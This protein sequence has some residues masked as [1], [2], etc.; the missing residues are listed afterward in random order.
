MRNYKEKFNIGDR[1]GQLTIGEMISRPQDHPS[2]DSTPRSY[3]RHGRLREC[4]CECGKVVLYSEAALRSPTLRSCGCLKIVSEE[5]RYHR[6]Q[7]QANYQSK[8]ASID[9][10]IDQARRAL[11]LVLDRPWMLK[12]LP[13]F[14][15]DKEQAWIRLNK[16][17][18]QKRLAKRLRAEELQA[19][20][21]DP[22][23]SA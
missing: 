16:W 10:E 21:K 20:A 8:I 22:K 3:L 12:Q 18:A 19:R 13:E 2:F 9:H 23:V 11:K 1:V 7:D 14:D 17:Q 6:K 5:E 15:K 4:H